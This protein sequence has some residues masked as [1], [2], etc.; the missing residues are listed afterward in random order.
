M[1]ETFYMNQSDRP[2]HPNNCP[3][4]HTIAIASGGEGHWDGDGC[5]NESNPTANI[6]MGIFYLL[7][8]AISFITYLKYRVSQF[9]Q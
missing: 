6:D 3:P 8:I 9:S 1:N 2:P 5:C 7:I 4:G